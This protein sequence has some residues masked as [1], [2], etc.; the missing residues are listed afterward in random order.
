ML[1]KRGFPSSRPHAVE[2]WLPANATPELGEVFEKLMLRL[3]RQW[4]VIGTAAVLAVALAVAY[5]LTAVPLYSARIDI[6]LQPSSSK[7]LNDFTEEVNP[8]DETAILSQIE[9]LQSEKI[10]ARVVDALDLH[11]DAAFMA[12]ASTPLS[13][14]RELLRSLADLD[15]WLRE[16]HPQVESDLRRAAAIRKV[17]S[18]VSVERIEKS[19]VLKVEYTSPFPAQAAAIA[20]AYGD[21][22]LADQLEAK[23]AATRSASDWLQQ[24]I[25]ELR[26]LALESDLAVQRFRDA[27]LHP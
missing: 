12:S 15:A 22:Y 2:E 17:T 6:L 18:N 3:R 11:E 5:V 27:L 20:R 14:L 4:R 9:L 10:A 8:T 23:Y 25:E 26:V 1:Q 7:L 21:A 16:P 19:Y 13:R 24:R